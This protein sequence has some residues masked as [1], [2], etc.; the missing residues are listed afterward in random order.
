MIPRLLL[1]LVLTAAPA[2]VA[3]AQLQIDVNRPRTAFDCNTPPGEN[4]YGSSERCLQELCAG[5]NVYN[6]YI[7][8]KNSRRRS[9]PCYGI[10]PTRFGERWTR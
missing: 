3:L 7:F 2:A 9:N 8:D 4:F 10:S 6:E 1:A 5:Q